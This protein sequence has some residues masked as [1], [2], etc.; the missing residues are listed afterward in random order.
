MK[1]LYLVLGKFHFQKIRNNVNA[2]LEA[3]F[4]LWYI[5]LYF[6]QTGLQSLILINIDKEISQE[7][8]L[9]TFGHVRKERERDRERERETERERNV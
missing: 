8:M 3:E 2:Y 5:L 9:I 6:T 1:T 7:L 4:T